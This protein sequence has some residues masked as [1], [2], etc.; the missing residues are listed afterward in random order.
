MRFT[1]GQWKSFDLRVDERFGQAGSAG[2]S[3]EAVLELTARARASY[4][5]EFERFLKDV[6]VVAAVGP[7]DRGADGRGVEQV[8][9]RG[10]VDHV[11]KLM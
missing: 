6:Q 3:E 5:V 11:C 7:A 1:S 10:L 4:G 2:E 9:K 8:A